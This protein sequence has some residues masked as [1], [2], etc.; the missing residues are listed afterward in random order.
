MTTTPHCPNCGEPVN[1]DW[2]ICPH[3]GQSNPAKL[4]KIRCRVCG[5]SAKATLQTCP[6]CGAQLEPKPWPVLQVILGGV[7]LVGFIFGFFQLWPIISVAPQQVALAVNPPTATLTPTRTPTATATFTPTPTATPSPTVTPTNMPTA[8]PSPTSTITPTPTQTPPGAPTATDTPTITPTP[9]PRF[10]KP[11]LLGPK[12]NRV[13]SRSEELVLRWRDMG[14]LKENEW[15]AVRMTWLQD[16]QL[17]FGGTNVKDNFWVV[18]PDQYW[19]LADQFTGRKYEWVV[20]IEEIVT[21]ANGS[22]VGRP[23]SEV[24]DPLVFL[25]Q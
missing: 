10:G 15:Y 11:V 13:Y 16:G 12:E 23:I 20:F 18:P 17:A 8:T 4:K 19:G 22:Q 3:C 1:S 14:P 21:D 24:S 9:T 7:L 6:H 2:R 25:W 5:R